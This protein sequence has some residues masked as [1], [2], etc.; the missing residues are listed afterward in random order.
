MNDR[1]DDIPRELLIELETLRPIIE[2]QGVVQLHH[3]DDRRPTY[4]LRFREFDSH[5]GLTRHRSVPL[6]SSP[7]VVQAVAELVRLWQDEFQAGE[8][9]VGAQSLLETIAPPSVTP[10][11]PA[12]ELAQELAGG[13]RRRRNQIGE[14][15]DK[16][17]N[18]PAEMFKFNVT[19]AFP[20]PRKGGRPLKNRLW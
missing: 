2:Q 11:D 15:F 5:A 8:Q 18:D 14:W 19:S 17:L 10:I 9:H 6:G 7:I 1:A 13:G 12:R 16:A 4:R 3:G 20:K